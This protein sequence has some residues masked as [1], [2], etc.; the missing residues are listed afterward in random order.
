MK[1]RTQSAFAALALARTLL[2]TATQDRE[3]MLEL[4]LRFGQ[5]GASLATLY[6]DLE[7]IN[8]DLT[9]LTITS[10]AG[11]PTRARMAVPCES[12]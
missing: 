8:L 3:L 1:A 6:H 7:Q 4:A 2:K 5:R 9:R 10:P 11:G 12:L